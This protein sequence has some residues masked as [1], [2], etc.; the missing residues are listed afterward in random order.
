MLSFR[1]VLLLI[2]PLLIIGIPTQQYVAD[3]RA[4]QI[5]THAEWE[6]APHSSGPWSISFAKEAWF[7]LT[8]LGVLISVAGAIY[9]LLRRRPIRIWLLHAGA[10]LLASYVALYFFGYL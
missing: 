7:R 6:S 10:V 8:L 3:R 1:Y 4:G 9:N 5:P 2:I